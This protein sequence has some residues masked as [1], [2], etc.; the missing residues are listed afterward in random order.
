L[1]PHILLPHILR[2]IWLQRRRRALERN[3]ESAG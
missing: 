3:N 1:L 2:A